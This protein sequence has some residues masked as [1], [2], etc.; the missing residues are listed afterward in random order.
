M[1]VRYKATYVNDDLKTDSATFVRDSRERYELG[2][3][4]LIKQFDQ[5]RTIQ[6]SRGANTYL[7][8]PDGA[9]A[10]AAAVAAAHAPTPKPPGLVNVNVSI[11][12]MGERKTAFDREARRVKTLIVRHPQPGA[13]DP[14]RLVIETDGWYIDPPKAVSAPPASAPAPG[15]G[16]QDE[17]KTTETGE[18]RLIGFPISY[19]TT[20]SEPGQQRVEADDDQHGRHRVRGAQARCRALRHSGGHDPGHGCAAARKGD[21][22]R[23][24]GAAG[25]GRAGVAARDK[26]PGTLRVGVPEVTNKSTQTVDTRALRS[27]LVAELEEQKIDVIPMAAAPPAAL[28]ALANERAV[29]YLLIAEVTDLKVSKPGGLTKMMKNDGR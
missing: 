25:A 28:N 27:R 2:D 22:R 20:Y 12:D 11:I 24:R 1:D 26:K 7:I 14:S 16:C 5:K 17:I 18:A 9:A 29:D 6:I 15:G 8:T 19:K 21:Q 4:I 13:C 10:A 23:E 3:T